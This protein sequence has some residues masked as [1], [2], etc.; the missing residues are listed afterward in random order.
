MDIETHRA[1]SA[2]G[3]NQGSDAGS[4]PAASTKE[5]LPLRLTQARLDL[6]SSACCLRPRRATASLTDP[7]RVPPAHPGHRGRAGCPA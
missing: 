7:R 3:L 2:A 1:H 5:D 4:I 6:V